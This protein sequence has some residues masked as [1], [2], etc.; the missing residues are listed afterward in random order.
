MNMNPGGKR[1]YLSLLRWSLIPWA[2]LE[3]RPRNEGRRAWPGSYRWSAACAV[4]SPSAPSCYCEGR[5]KVYQKSGT[6]LQSEKYRFMKR[7]CNFYIHKTKHK[8]KHMAPKSWALD[9]Q[10]KISL[11]RE[12]APE[13]SN[14]GNQPP[15]NKSS[16][17]VLTSCCQT[18]CHD[19]IHRQHCKYTLWELRKTAFHL[20]LGEGITK[21]KRLGTRHESPF[22]SG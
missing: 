17:K 15:C 9:L 18:K 13:L 22:I 5:N 6:H 1:D 4:D 2:L 14:G 8:H 19:S 10:T 16:G 3:N 21:E 20:F 12:C 7:V 11:K